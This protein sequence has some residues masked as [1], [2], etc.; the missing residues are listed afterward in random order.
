MSRKLLASRR[1]TAFFDRARA[2]PLGDLT[3]CSI[4]N[5][6]YNQILAAVSTSI[7]GNG[8]STSSIIN[9][10]SAFR[11]IFTTQFAYSTCNVRV[12]CYTIQGRVGRSIN[13]D[14]S[15][16]TRRSFETFRSLGTSQVVLVSRQSDSS[17][18]TDN[19]DNDHQLDEGEAFLHFFHEI[20]SIRFSGLNY[21]ISCGCNSV[22]CCECICFGYARVIIFCIFMW[23]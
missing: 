22:C 8:I 5:R 12:A 10:Y 18:D 7:E 1:Q 21:S 15:L 11:E 20:Y 17:Q 2:N 19:G 6:R 9:S 3:S 23:L 16:Q 14:V 13:A 4:K